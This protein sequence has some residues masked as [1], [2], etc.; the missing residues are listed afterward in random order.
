MIKVLLDIYDK[1]T[2]YN[3]ML[4]FINLVISSHPLDNYYTG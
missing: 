4:R 2:F 1:G 3:Y